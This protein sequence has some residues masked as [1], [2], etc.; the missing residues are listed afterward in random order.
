[1]GKFDQ[2]IDFLSVPIENHSIINDIICLK[3]L[4]LLQKDKWKGTKM[5]NDNVNNLSVLE[6]YMTKVFVWIML[7]VT[8]AITCAG[9]TLT[10]FKALGL[11]PSVPWAGL[12]ASLGMDIIYVV[13]GI[14]LI[15]RAIVNGSLRKG[16]LKTGKLY[17]SIIIVIQ[18]NCIQYLIPSREFW[19]FIFFFVLLTVFFLDI[20]MTGIVSGFVAISYII[21]LFS[22][23][24]TALPVQDSLFI[25]EVILRTIA[26]VLSL[27]SICLLTWFVGEFLAN[28]KRDE[29]EQKHN[30]AQNILDQA[31]EI[32]NRLSATSQNVLQTTETQSSSSQ[33]LS[34]ITEELTQLSKELL[35]HSRENTENLSQLNKTSEQVSEQ[36]SEVNQMSRQLVNLSKENENS[37]NQLMAGS[38]VVVSANQNTMDAVAHLLEGTEQMINTLALIDEIASSTNLLALNASIEAARAGEAGRGFAV[39]ANEIGSLASNTQE[40]LKE[41]NQLM[42][43]LEQDTSLVSNSIDTSSKKLEEQNTVM[44]ETIAKVRN[45]MKLLNECLKSVESVHQQNKHQK[46]L[47]EQTYEYN[48][49]MENQIEIQDERFS[50]ISN[51]IQNNAKEISGLACLADQLNDVI[52]QLNQLLE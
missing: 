16:M 9:V 7:L 4:G 28:A 21:F 5:D 2:I 18:Y 44:E 41:I 50:E 17:L 46:N 13:I 14:V 35:S 37:I 1:M 40:S 48:S 3:I 47:V 33:E 30:Q 29:L 52:N 42:N 36:I 34:A 20:R 38:Q 32:G 39:V 10:M 22:R 23:W 49:I 8:G 26:I 19:G 12:L 45:M 6:M 51:V 11:Y 31:A 15:K 25:P 24:K 27:G 43:A